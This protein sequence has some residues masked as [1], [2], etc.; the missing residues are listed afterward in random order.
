MEPSPPHPQPNKARR[1]SL[2]A[3]THKWMFLTHNTHNKRKLNP[4]RKYYPGDI[5]F[6]S[7]R[8]RVGESER[9]RK[10][11]RESEG[12]RENEGERESKRVRKRE[13]ERDG[14]RKNRRSSHWS[15][16]FNNHKLTLVLCLFMTH[17][18]CY[19]VRVRYF[20]VF[21]CLTRRDTTSSSGF[22]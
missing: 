18:A 8:L 1:R 10:R 15:L 13:S 16:V 2:P 19:Y 4:I 3:S 5:L 9:E 12:K 6:F 21:M 20:C 11:E 14:E 17:F 22:L 7:S